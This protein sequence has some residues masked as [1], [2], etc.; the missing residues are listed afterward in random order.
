M[1]SP[2]GR[3]LPLVGAKARSLTGASTPRTALRSPTKHD[4][5]RKKQPTRAGECA[6]GVP[7]VLRMGEAMPADLVPHAQ[8]PELAARV[9]P[10]MLQ[11][12]RQIQRADF[13]MNKGLDAETAESLRQLTQLGLVDPGP[14][15]PGTVAFR[16]E[17]VLD[18]RDSNKRTLRSTGGPCSNRA[19]HDR[20]AVMLGPSSAF[21]GVSANQTRDTPECSG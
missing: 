2:W 13:I 19:H 10:G 21:G 9:T 7:V 6:A 3:R 11:V 16:T 18:T 8:I 17:T 12:L 14:G 4:L 1:G 20:V 5:V 15:V